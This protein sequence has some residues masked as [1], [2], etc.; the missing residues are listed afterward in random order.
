MRHGA[1]APLGTLRPP[2]AGTHPT[3][4]EPAPSS[5]ANLPG[6]HHHHHHGPPMSHMYPGP[7]PAVRT[8]STLTGAGTGLTSG[9]PS[10]AGAGGGLLGQSYVIHSQDGTRIAHGRAVSRRDMTCPP[11]FTPR[12]G[13]PLVLQH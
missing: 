13:C 12:P 1:S 7:A 8:P 4:P 2:G 6:Q 5:P 3:G 10:L 9:G 11:R